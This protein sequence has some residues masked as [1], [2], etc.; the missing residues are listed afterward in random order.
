MTTQAKTRIGAVSY[1]NSKPLIEAFPAVLSDCELSLDLPS[2]LA[3]RLFQGRIDIGL[4]PAIEYFRRGGVQA[5]TAGDDYQI[6]SDACIACRGPV[7]S[8]RVF[9]RVPPPAVRTLAVDEGSR[10]SIALA[11]VLLHERHRLKPDLVPLPIEADPNQAKADAVLVIGDRAMRSENFHGF[12]EQWDLGQAWF[13][14]YAL[15]FV[16]AMWVGRER[17]STPRLAR[18]LELARD[19]GLESIE[20][21]CQR[22]ASRYQLSIEDCSD[23]F[24]NKLQFQ[25][26]PEAVAGLELFRQKSI[27]LGLVNSNASLRWLEPWSPVTPLSTLT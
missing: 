27:A 1:L 18:Q 6:V 26:T 15:P 11:Q 20:Q 21:I 9:F 3:D 13:D 14:E 17:L 19:L 23:Y 5:A 16:F 12:S 25:L 22:E 8:V 7:R 24:L 4:I 10:T 2:R